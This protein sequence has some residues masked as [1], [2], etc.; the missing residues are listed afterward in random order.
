MKKILFLLIVSLVFSSCSD[1]DETT[2]I[3]NLRVNH[4]K[5]TTNGFF[6]GGLGVALLVEEGNQIGQ[7]NFTPT[8]NGINNF[9]YELGSTYDLRVSKTI[10]PNPPQDASNIRIDLIEIIS[11]TL[12]SPDTEFKVRLTQNHT[13][14][15]FNNWVFVNPDNDYSIINSSIEIICENLCDE[16]STKINNQEQLTGV[17]VHG[18]TNEYILKEILNE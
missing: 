7:N 8:F 14:G 15:T 11:K 4:Y 16:L 12:V 6:F 13:N 5:T 1:D 17:F 18:N 9:D 3:T 2:E 10:L